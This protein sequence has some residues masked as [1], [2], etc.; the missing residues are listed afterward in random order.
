MTDSSKSFAI[1]EFDELINNK[2]LV[3]LVPTSWLTEN[4]TLCFWPPKNKEHK[5]QE[6]VEFEHVPEK[7]WT[8]YHVKVI[9]KASKYTNISIIL[10]LFY[11][12]I[13]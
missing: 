7:A 3:E 6:F 13:Y 1:V 11:L 12:S 9:S 2:K 4:E 8:T 10:Y 5:V